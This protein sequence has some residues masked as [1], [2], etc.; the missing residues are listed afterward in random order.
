[1]AAGVSGV[2]PPATSLRLSL[3]SIPVLR[4][5]TMV[6]PCAA[7]DSMDSFSGI[8][9]RPA[10]RV[11]ITLCVIPGRV[12]SISRAEAAPQKALTPGV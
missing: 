6:A 4:K 1:M 12:Y 9:V 11:M 8:G 3:S 7:K 5:I 10:M 2:Y